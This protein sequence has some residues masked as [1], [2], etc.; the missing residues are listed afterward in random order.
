G[1]IVFEFIIVSVPVSISISISRSYIS[2]CHRIWSLLSRV[3]ITVAYVGGGPA[4]GGGLKTLLVYFGIINA[5]DQST[6]VSAVCDSVKGVFFSMLS[7]PVHICDAGS[8]LAPDVFG[9]F[10]GKR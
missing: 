9:A 6:V 4:S 5:R 8:N 1:F 3:V 7:I 10:P 2:V